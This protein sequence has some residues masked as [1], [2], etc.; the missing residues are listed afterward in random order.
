MKPDA[1]CKEDEHDPTNV[2]CV[3]FRLTNPGYLDVVS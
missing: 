2:A 1:R 3:C